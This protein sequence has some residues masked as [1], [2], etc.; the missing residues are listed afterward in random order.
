MDLTNE[1][2]SF[3]NY[4]G[5]NSLILS[6]TAGSGKTWCCVQRL[7]ELLNRKVAPEKIIFFSYTNA[8]VNELKERINNNDIKI[9]TIHSFCLGFLKRI[10]K[11]KKI[12][13]FY[14]FLSWYK[15]I[16]QPADENELEIF[17]EKVSIL[18]DDIDYLSSKISS[19]KLQTIENIE[20]E[21]PLYYEEYQ[22]FLKE[23]GSMDFSDMLIET[24]R[25]LK[26]N[27][28]LRLIKNKYDY[29]FVDEYQDT[30]TSQMDIVLSLNAKYYYLIGDRF[31]SIFGYSGV[32]CDIVE[33]M[34]NSRRQIEKMALTANF[35][36]DTSI[37]YNSNKYSDLK[38]IPTHNAHGRVEK[39]L[40]FINDVENLIKHK[41]EV[42]VLARTNAVIREF[43]CEL[44]KRRTPLNYFNYIKPEEIKD[45]KQNKLSDRTKKKL[46]ELK[47]YFED[48]TDS[49]IKFIEE[50]KNKK[51]FITTI[52]KAKGREFDV[53]VVINSIPPEIVEEN[54]LKE[55]I[56]SDL[57]NYCS[58]DPNKEKDFESKNVHYV[59]ISRP[60]HELYF[61]LY[62]SK[63]QFN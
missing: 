54:N 38:A 33:E 50:N 56:N 1:Q 9:T 42:V 16:Y 62:L 41:N 63:K 22:K 44:L 29:V 13:T 59:A 7:K 40:I 39:K 23:T 48:S 26:D 57:L 14:D 19:Y 45:F 17:E 2:D 34:L 53:C 49:V 11:D 35:R 61:M 15:K 36:S 30:S 55:K 18:Y 37:V 47:V 25:L 32:N 12:A 60:K 6:A 3:V 51:S 58:F 28:F 31:Q 52:H 10:K 5:K 46:E 4:S 21:V 43:E 20:V 24:K 27:R 8:A